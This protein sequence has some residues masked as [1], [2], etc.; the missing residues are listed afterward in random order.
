[1]DKQIEIIDYK[2]SIIEKLKQV[3]TYDMVDNNVGIL[4][5]VV[6]KQKTYIWIRLYLKNESQD[7]L[8]GDDITITYVPSGE[9]IHTKFICYGK[10]QTEHDGNVIVNYEAEDDNRVLCFMVDID[11]INTSEDIPY[12]RTLFIHSNHYEF[13]L[14]KRDDLTFVVDRNDIKLDYFDVSL[15]LNIH[16]YLKK[17]PSYSIRFINKKY[18]QYVLNLLRYCCSK[19]I[20]IPPTMKPLTEKI[21]NSIY[22]NMTPIESAIVKNRYY[23]EPSIST[24]HLILKYGGKIGSFSTWIT[25]L[26]N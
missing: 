10:K 23:Q 24:I 26:L 1:M 11:Y 21:Y 9:K 14:T 4:T 25:E 6:E 18:L 7:I 16:T 15:P 2:L 22:S 13:Q 5:E 20:N 19:N 8:V 17:L 12:L 3:D